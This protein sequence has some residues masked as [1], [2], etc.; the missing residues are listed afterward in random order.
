MSKAR[1]RRVRAERDELA[2]QLRAADADLR[3]LSARL[4]ETKHLVGWFDPTKDDPKTFRDD[5]WQA[6]N[7]DE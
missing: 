7:G 1:I 3:D 4:S 5:L 6:V 2:E